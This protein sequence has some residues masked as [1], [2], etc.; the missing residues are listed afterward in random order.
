MKINCKHLTVAYQEK[1]VEN[2]ST[3]Q[4]IGAR[5]SQCDIPLP[6]A[7]AALQDHVNNRYKIIEI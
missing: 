6:I 3:P 1:W 4:I 2:K 5:C 7:Q